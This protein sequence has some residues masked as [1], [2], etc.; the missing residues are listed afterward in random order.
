[1]EDNKVIEKQV[2]ICAVQRNLEANIISPSYENMIL[3]PVFCD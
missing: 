3:F 2:H 1:M